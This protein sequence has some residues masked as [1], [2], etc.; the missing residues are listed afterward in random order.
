MDNQA[1]KGSSENGNSDCGKPALLDWLAYHLSG[2]GS[3]EMTYQDA[4]RIMAHPHA[5]GRAKAIEAAL[6]ILNHL[7]AQPIDIAN[8]MSYKP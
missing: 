7:G 5:Y 8:A 1:R 6:F 4:S 2:K 3:C